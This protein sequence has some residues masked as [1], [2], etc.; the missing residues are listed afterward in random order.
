MNTTLL[1]RTMIVAAWLAISFT[2][3]SF[4]QEE[5]AP[6]IVSDQEQEQIIQV[7]ELLH[8]QATDVFAA[9]TELKLPV[10]MT[11]TDNNR[12][13]L[14]GTKN[15][16]KYVTN[17]IIPLL[18]LSSTA[19]A[20]TTTIIKLNNR[21][22]RDLIEALHNAAPSPALRLGLHEI[23][24][25]LA[26]H[27]TP[28]NVNAIRSFLATADAPHRP[29]TLDFFFLRGMVGTSESHSPN[30]LP[31]ALQAVA[32]PLSENGFVDLT[33]LAPIRVTTS[34]GESFKVDFTMKIGD[35]SDDDGIL[36]FSVKGFANASSPQDTVS[37]SIVAK[38]TAAIKSRLRGGTNFVVAT[39]LAAKSGDY[40]VLS[41]A[42]ST[43]AS[44]E[45]IVLVVRATQG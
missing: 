35:G 36:E 38:M 33:M 21:P 9:L 25:T 8:A 12:I 43:T 31:P 42:P 1:Q 32:A 5:S 4:G 24:R 2:S 22:S 44:G 20:I 3:S 7:V 40:T 27:G 37:I 10:T 34:E 30:K 13:L 28:E 45:A 26:I 39:N 41:A 16:I 17:T 18:D 14:R 15:D 11:T 29:I 23:S 6:S 19:G